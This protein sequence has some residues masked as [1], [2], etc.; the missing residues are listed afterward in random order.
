M[1][2]ILCLVGASACGKDTL[3]K[4]ILKKSPY[5]V[6][7]VR[8]TTRPM[9]ENEINGVDYYFVDNEKF[10]EKIL[11]LDMVEATM[12]NNWFYGTDKTSLNEKMVNVL[13]CDLDAVEQLIQDPKLKVVVVYIKTKPKERLIRALKRESNPNIDE[14]IRRFRDDE[15]KYGFID[16]LN[17]PYFTIENDSKTQ[18][19]SAVGKICSIIKNLF[20]N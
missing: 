1:I 9:R 16:V 2:K 15:K 6:P 4:Q 20:N 13:I 19:K 10:I 17:I 11:K 7:I 14:I 3:L 8:Y 5:A 12:F 18:K